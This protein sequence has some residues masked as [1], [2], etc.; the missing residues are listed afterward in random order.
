MTQLRKFGCAV[1]YGSD[2]AALANMKLAKSDDCLRR[3]EGCNF[4]RRQRSS[5]FTNFMEG[6]VN[7]VYREREVLHVI[8][9]EMHTSTEN[10]VQI[11]R[12]V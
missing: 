5:L 2:F 3:F 12:F 4:L 7:H 9:S 6:A 8:V 1:Y 10:A 11:Y